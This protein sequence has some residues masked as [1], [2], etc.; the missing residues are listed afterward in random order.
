MFPSASAD[1]RESRPLTTLTFVRCGMR[2]PVASRFPP[3][4]LQYKCQ[5]RYGSAN[6]PLGYRD[7]VGMR[8]WPSLA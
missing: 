3:I 1:I 2:G 6:L 7:G 8:L 4:N 5:Y